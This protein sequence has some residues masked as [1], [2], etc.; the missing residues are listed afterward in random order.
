MGK[1][2]VAYSNSHRGRHA[3]TRLLPALGAALLGVALAHCSSFNTAPPGVDPNVFPANYK[4][5]VMTF[6]RTNPYGLDGAISAEL[7][8]PVLKPFGTDSRYV[9]CM[10]AAG[11]NWRKE[12]M[13]VFYGGEINQFVDAT[14]EA[15]KDAAYA[16][17]PELPAMLTQL[18]KK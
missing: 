9:G 7:S 5:A 14:E 2:P 15:C 16:P 13:A 3:S 10:R 8:P 18:K 1:P 4:A 12:K 6:L 17:F 11:P